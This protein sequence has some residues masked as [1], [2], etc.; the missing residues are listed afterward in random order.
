[1]SSRPLVACSTHGACVRQSCSATWAHLTLPLRPWRSSSSCSPSTTPS[2]RW[3]TLAS[4]AAATS[5]T[6]TTS[7]IGSFSACRTSRLASRSTEPSRWTSCSTL[8]SATP[9]SFRTLTRSPTARSCSTRRAP[10]W[11]SS[12]GS[13]SLSI[14][15]WIA[16][17]ISWARLWSD[18]PRTFSTLSWSSSLCSLR[19]ARWLLA[20][21]RDHSGLSELFQ[22]ALHAVPFVARRFR[23]CHAAHVFPDPGP[24]VLFELRVHWL[25]YP[26]EHVHGY[27]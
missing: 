27:Y 12:P 11:S 26:L 6:R 5:R 10:S 17:W 21:R 19:T 16:P 14:S 25:L 4:R 13:R 9:P 7:S 18:P 15:R 2:R 20:L 23:L 22:D 8:C 1:M 3:S 24:A